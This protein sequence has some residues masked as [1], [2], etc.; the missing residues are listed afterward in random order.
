VADRLV[1]PCHG[2]EFSFEGQV[3]EGPAERPLRRYEVG[4]EGN[5][6]IIHLDRGVGG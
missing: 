4:E 1:C 2:S 6:L 5:A 3:L